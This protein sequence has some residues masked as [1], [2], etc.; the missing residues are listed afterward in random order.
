VCLQ[1]TLSV[2]LVISLY[3]AAASG[4][5]LPRF[6]IPASIQMKTAKI[7]I[8]VMILGK[9]SP[10]NCAYSSKI[11]IPLLDRRLGFLV[12]DPRLYAKLVGRWTVETERHFRC[13]LVER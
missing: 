11:A 8:S 7:E 12:T 13:A 1:C 4:F 9:R 6:L 2:Q 3:P 5:L 10:L